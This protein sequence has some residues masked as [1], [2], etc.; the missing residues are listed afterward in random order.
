MNQGSCI[1]TFSVS[2]ALQTGIQA[3]GGSIMVPSSAV[4]PLEYLQ[5]GGVFYVGW[6]P[7]QPDDQAYLFALLCQRKPRCIWLWESP[8]LGFLA[9]YAARFLGV[10]AL[11]TPD[12][13]EDPWH[14]SQATGPAPERLSVQWLKAAYTPVMFP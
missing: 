11:A 9:A 10:P 2:P 3:I 7:H 12:N 5:Q 1:L 8:E 6:Q 4:P 13:P 14:G